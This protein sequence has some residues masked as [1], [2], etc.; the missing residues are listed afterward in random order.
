[1]TPQE[2]RTILQHL[3]LTQAGVAAVLGVSE[4]AVRAWA[5]GYRNIPAPAAKLLQL[6]LDGSLTTEQVQRA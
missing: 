4:R 6:M 1:M 5:D 2:I 3:G